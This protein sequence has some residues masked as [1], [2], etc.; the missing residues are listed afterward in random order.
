MVEQEPG[1]EG[2]VVG[3]GKGQEDRCSKQHQVGPQGLDID[4]QGLTAHP[5]QDQQAQTQEKAEQ[6]VCVVPS[7]IG[8]NQQQC[9]EPGG[10]DG[11]GVAHIKSQI[12]EKAAIKGL[13]PG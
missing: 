8:D 10:G 1:G 9:H 13:L 3:Q 4:P 12:G 2:T 5:A 11:C 7:L 6:A